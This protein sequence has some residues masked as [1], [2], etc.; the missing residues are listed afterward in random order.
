MSMY[1]HGIKNEYK[2][3]Y[4][5]IQT[6][7]LYYQE[8]TNKK[9]DNIT[10]TCW[11]LDVEETTSRESR[12]WYLRVFILPCIRKLTSANSWSQRFSTITKALSVEITLR[13]EKANPMSWTEQNEEWIFLVH[14]PFTWKSVV[15]RFPWI[16]SE[17]YGENK[18]V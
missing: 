4:Q 3:Y 14:Q 18:E 13:I 15:G 12:S 5:K 16:G 2:Y 17:S 9:R 8:K 11:T 7:I 10:L 1:I 6:I